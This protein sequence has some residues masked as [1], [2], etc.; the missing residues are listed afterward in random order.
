M[1][2]KFQVGYDFIHA[3]VS[4]QAH[5]SISEYEAHTITLFTILLFFPRFIV[6]PRVP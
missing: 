2:D 1:S 5:I 4:V 3:S 6:C